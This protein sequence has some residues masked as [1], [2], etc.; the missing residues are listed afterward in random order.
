MSWM[1][2]DRV[3]AFR[4][5]PLNS[6]SDYLIPQPNTILRPPLMH[7]GWLVDKDRMYDY[8][9]EHGVNAMFYGHDGNHRNYF[10]ACNEALNFLLEDLGIPDDHRIEIVYVCKGDYGPNPAD[11]EHEN[12]HPALSIATNYEG[13][14]PREHANK[15]QDFVAPG[16][17][18]R[19]FL[20]Q[21]QWMWTK[22][23]K[24]AKS[25]GTPRLF[26]HISLFTLRSRLTDAPPSEKGMEKGAPAVPK[27]TTN[28]SATSS[29]IAAQSKAD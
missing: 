19:W 12:F 9:L 26:N 29:D 28:K 20:N 18:P 4:S 15:L 1:I 21:D 14:I 16:A 17:K 2:Q 8:A 6:I 23:P 3:R 5:Q 13:A 11:P 24:R 25:T 27:D 10:D 22:A 7:L